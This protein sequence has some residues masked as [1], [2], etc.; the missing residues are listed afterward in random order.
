MNLMMNQGRCARVLQPW[1]VSETGSIELSVLVVRR[2]LRLYCSMYCSLFTPERHDRTTKV[3]NSAYERVFIS[4][5]K[6]PCS[7]ELLFHELAPG[8]SHCPSTIHQSSNT[9]YRDK[10]SISM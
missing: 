6:R 9:L 5:F 1:H 4:D 8:Y 2:R 7:L 10:L 3:S